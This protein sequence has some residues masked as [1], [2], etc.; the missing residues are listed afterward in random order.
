MRLADLPTRRVESDTAV[1]TLSRRCGG[2][3]GREQDDLARPITG[4]K[5]RRRLKDYCLRVMR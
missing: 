4:T 5:S 1:D 3:I 2:V